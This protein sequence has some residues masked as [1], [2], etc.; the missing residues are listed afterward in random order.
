MEAD[1]PFK[2]EAFDVA[3]HGMAD[4]PRHLPLF[5]APLPGEALTGWMHRFAGPLGVRPE[6]LFFDPEDRPFITRRAWWHRPPPALLERLARRTGLSTTDLRA[7]TFSHGTSDASSDEPADR[8][9]RVRTWCMPR[10]SAPLHRYDVCPR[11]LAEDPIPYIRKTW[12]LGWFS[13]CPAHRLLLVAQCPECRG[14]FRTPTLFSRGT[15]RPDHCHCRHHLLGIVQRPAHELTLQLQLALLIGSERA[16]IDLPALGRLPWPVAMA[17]FDVLLDMM[18]LEAVPRPTHPLFRRMQDELRIA[19]RIG[20]SSYDGLLI[21]AWLLEH[22]PQRLHAAIEAL[23]AECPRRTNKRWQYLD[24][25]VKR[26]VETLLES[27]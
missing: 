23:E 4:G 17:L 25:D 6:L 16:A 7:M 22:W 13:V 8:F 10:V 19:D 3:S 5:A 9:A 2:V 27:D 21:L 15:F 12:T 26:A 1:E 18:W 24:P 11:C 20:E 14:R